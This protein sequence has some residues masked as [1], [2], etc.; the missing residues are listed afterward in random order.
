[1]IHPLRN[2]LSRHRSPVNFWLHMLGIPATVLAVPLA[3]AGWWWTAGGL[4]VAGYAL[5]FVGHAVEGNA[6]GEELLLRR[7]IGRPLEN[8]PPPADRRDLE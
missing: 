8:P 1:M 2:W 5:Q 7:L 3:V 6:S 4:F